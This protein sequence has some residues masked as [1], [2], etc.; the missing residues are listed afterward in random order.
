MNIVYQNKIF[1][2]EKKALAIFDVDWT[3]IKPKNGNT[4]PKDKNDWQWLRDSVPSILKKFNKDKYR[5][6]FVTDQSKSWKIDMIKDVINKLN[7][8]II[9][10]IAMDKNSYKPNPEFF[11][12]KFKEKYNKDES[13]Y[14]GDAAGR[15]GDWSDKDKIFA[16][17]I[18]VKF[19]TPEE[20]FPL[21]KEKNKNKNKDLTKKEKEVVIMIGYPGSGKTTIAKKHFEEKGYIR[22]DGDSLKTPNK[23]LK[24]AEKHITNNSVIFDATNGTK[25]KRAYFIKFAKEKGLPVRCIWNTTPIDKAMEQNKERAKKGGPKVPDIVFYVYRKNFQEPTTD[26]CEIIKVQ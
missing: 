19:Y 11:L 1:R 26:E 22:I 21:K 6:V 20:I 25:E 4:F 23:M 7:I 18:N 24:E 5:I 3:L 15:E 17:N 8:P 13:F 10:I 12:E 16:S 2:K 9:S 14:V